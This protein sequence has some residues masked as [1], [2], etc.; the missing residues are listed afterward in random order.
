MYGKVE[1]EL[2]AFLTSAIKASGYLH[3]PTELTQRR[4]ERHLLDKRLEEP[5]NWTGRFGKAR[6]LGPSQNIN[7]V[8]QSSTVQSNHF[9]DP[10]PQNF[11]SLR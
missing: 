6:N 10:I 11:R 9:S 5:Q 1:T 8:S 2:Q 3:V 4:S 7:P